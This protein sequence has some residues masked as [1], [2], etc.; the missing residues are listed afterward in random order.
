MNF[1]FK[2]FNPD[3][4]DVVVVPVFEGEKLSNWAA[5]FDAELG[6]VIQKRMDKKSFE[7]KA[8]E[9]ATLSVDSEVF[10][11]KDV[12]LYGFGQKDELDVDK[13]R[14]LAINLDR[15]IK[16]TGENNIHL[17]GRDLEEAHNGQFLVA[18]L[19]DAI[20]ANSYKFDKYKSSA[21]NDNKGGVNVQ[22]DVDNRNG[23][24]AHFDGLQA[25]TESQNW[26]K[27]LGNE[28]PNHLTPQNYAKRIT[29]ELQQFE[30]VKVKTLDMDDMRELGMGGALAV[31]QGST[32][33]PGCMVVIEYNGTGSDAAPSLGLVGKGVTFDTGGYNLKP[34]GSMADMK[35][36]MCG[37]ASVVGA[38]RSIAA[39]G[40]DAK[41]VAV[42]GL[43]E[44]MVDGNSFRP[45]DVITM[46]NGKTVEIGNTDAEGRLVLADALTYIQQE[47]N[48]D[49]V[50]D[51]ATLTGAMVVALAD[52]YTGVF[53][54]DDDL[55]NKIETAGKT[56]GEPGWRMPLGEAFTKAVQG[57]V[58]DLS[59]TGK[60]KGAGASTAAAFL[61]AFIDEGRPWAHLDIAGTSSNGG[62]A[63]GVGVRWMDEFVKSNVEGA[64]PRDRNCWVPPQ[65]QS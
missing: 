57:S 42:V 25:I 23:H 37:S 60:M 8:G 1:D 61:E 33:N 22:A 38:M 17:I 32:M 20:S 7:G 26:A 43:V 18:E 35:T 4:T 14:K 27:D 2:Y 13:I 40:A 34:G 62:V 58:A 39:R 28:P 53:A 29:S 31:S 41:V 64:L 59:N 55:W 45:S 47:Y 50:M 10:G 52:T 63:T 30:N 46:M 5:E 56:S 11:V 49:Q 3:E 6:G 51:F 9:H 24:V 19:F 54:N 15:T 65:L 44:N 12:V 16:A 48:P 36:D 21:S